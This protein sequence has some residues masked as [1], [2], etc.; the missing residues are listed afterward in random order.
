M[1]VAWHCARGARP[2]CLAQILICDDDA[3]FRDLLRLVLSSRG[4]AVTVTDNGWTAVETLRE[5]SFDIVIL[6][7]HMPV[8]DGMT[9]AR[10]GREM[11]RESPRPR[12]IGVTA[13][14]DGLEG[15]DPLH[16]IFDAI[17]QKPINIPA[18][19]DVIE[20]SL[21]NR[22]DET[23]TGKILELW[24]AR[25]FDRCPRV[26]FGS[27]PAALTCIQLDV[28][29]DLTR[30]ENPDFILLTDEI[31]PQD[32]G[33]LRTAGNL[34]CLPAVDMTGRMG[35]MADA[36]F[37]LTDLS[38]WTDVAAAARAFGSRRTQLT[39]RFLNAADLPEQLL[40]YIYVSGRDFGPIADPAQPRG[41]CYPGLFPAG[42]IIAAA[43]RLVQRGL[44]L[45]NRSR[46]GASGAVAGPRRGA[47]LRIDQHGGRKAHR[48][49]PVRLSGHRNPV[50]PPAA[51]CPTSRS[52]A[53]STWRGQRRGASS[54]ASPRSVKAAAHGLRA[55]QTA[56]ARSIRRRLVCV[57]ASSA[58]SRP[59]R[60]LTSTK[61]TT[62]PRRAMTSI[63]PPAT[64][65]PRSMIR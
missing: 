22:R 30:P 64:L 53:S 21:R 52:N 32:V 49:A 18:L 39:Q 36:S 26:R 16:G 12:F 57:T 58:S 65:N 8:L 14:P 46:P 15:R 28:V 55:S 11:A 20:T 9:V 43:E 61:A 29:F 6:D 56:A 23:A 48:H 24:Q 59:A 35:P 63:S 33:E 31:Q 3:M 7:Y 41:I 62:A 38:T 13:D 54:R 5:A 34:F 40:A 2:I 19:L 10:K 44:L 37:Q 1:S 45:R 51:Q 47:T 50:G 42:D 25:G 27:Q 4:H 17:V 60:R